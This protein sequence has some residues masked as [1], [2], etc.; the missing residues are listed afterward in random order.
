MNSS[1]LC[2]FKCWKISLRSFRIS[3]QDNS[4]FTEDDMTRNGIR[5]IRIQSEIFFEPALNIQIGLPEIALVR[6]DGTIR[7]VTNDYSKS[8]YNPSYS[9]VSIRED[10]LFIGIYVDFSKM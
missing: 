2:G 4:D 3:K 8:R 6:L 10:N 5:Y 7:F 9:K 1:N